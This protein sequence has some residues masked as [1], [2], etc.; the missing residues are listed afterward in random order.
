VA[1]FLG[2]RLLHTAQVDVPLYAFQTSLGGAGNAVA[3]GAH[4]YQH[5]S[6]IPRVTVVSRAT[7]YSHLDPLLATPAKNAFLQ[8]VVPWLRRVDS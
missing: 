1:S 7:T 3:G 4:Y 6:R 2:L 8:T 5:I